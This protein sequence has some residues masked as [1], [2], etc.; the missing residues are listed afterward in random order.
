M[1][2]AREEST[3][4]FVHSVK[5]DE[6]NEMLHRRA[7]AWL[8]WTTAGIV[9][10]N[11][12]QEKTKAT[13]PLAQV[14][15]VSFGG[16]TAVFRTQAEVLDPSYCCFSI[17]TIQ[18][19]TVDLSFTNAE[20]TEKWFFLIMNHAQQGKLSR[21]SL[22]WLRCALRMQEMGQLM[23]C[24]TKRVLVSILNGSFRSRSDRTPS[25][26]VDH[27]QVSHIT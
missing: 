6:A 16:C 15:C 23:H 14:S 12:S 11:A 27:L 2:E 21:P 19:S 1:E 4:C 5:L 3:P 9:V 7:P 26:Q 10:M 17:L 24:T 18:G 22:L 20:T 13:I 8:I 25:R